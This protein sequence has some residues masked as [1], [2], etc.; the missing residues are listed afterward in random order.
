M[1]HI[2]LP[3]SLTNLGSCAFRNCE[4]LDSIILPNG[5]NGIENYTFENCS[6]LKHVSIPSNISFIGNSAFAHC[7][8]LTSIYLNSNAIV[9]GTK[10][11]EGIKKI[12]GGQVIKCILGDNVTTIGDYAFSGCKN[13]ES[14]TISGSV[15]EIGNHAFST[16]SALK[17]VIVPNIQE[18]YDISFKDAFS[19]PLRY[20]HHLYKDEENEITTLYIPD[21][22]VTINDYAFYMCSSLKSVQIPNSLTKIGNDAFYNC[23]IDKVIVP[24][25]AAWCGISFGSTFGGQLYSDE[26]TEITDLIIPDGVKNINSHA[27]YGFTNLASV[28]IPSSVE[29]IGES[30]FSSCE[31]LNKVIIPDLGAWCSISFDY[32]GSPLGC[33]HHIYSDKDTEIF[34]LV[35]PNGVVTIN[36]YAFKEA[37]FLTSIT[38]PEGVSRIG[39]YAFQSCNRVTN[40][41]LSEGVKELGL[42][43][44]SGCSELSVVTIPSSL[45][46]IDYYG[47]DGCNKLS[48]VI[49]PDL[50]SWCKV[51]FSD[52][53][54]NPLT[55]S[56]RIF[57]DTETEIK[58]LNIPDDVIT[59]SKYA[60]SNCSSLSSITLPQSVTNFGERAFSGCNGVT[61]IWS[62][63]TAPYDIPDN[64]FEYKDESGKTDGYLRAT[65]YVPTGTK[66][67][68]ET[69]NGWKNFKYIEE[70]DPTGILHLTADKKKY[71][72][73]IF[74]LNGQHLTTPQKGI[75]I[76]NGQKVI[77]K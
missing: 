57:S 40:L 56:H 36:D 52:K 34:D 20:A 16:C 68:Y 26:N 60:F 71:L 4:K 74:D 63:I 30:A 43:A 9:S 8:N 44:F 29:S 22:I 32:S 65:L 42:W 54:S 73:S 10:Q 18:W 77:V 21:G 59:I 55:M 17:K 58:E 12:F 72:N 11:D 6:S 19:N 45:N 1:N 37:S 66:D 75:N 15:K 25:I 53:Y 35:I 14:V 49:I 38:I 13:L 51:S 24:D 41:Y 67:R 64:V 5:L 50:T 33:A 48:K 23:N 31:G 2:Y 3:E 46:K 70:Y 62:R 28:Y 61:S 69:T 47:F 7:T 27:F 39:K 76:I